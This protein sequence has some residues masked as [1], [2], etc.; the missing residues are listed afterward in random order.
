VARAAAESGLVAAVALLERHMAPAYTPVQRALAFGAV[1][2]ELGELREQALG[3]GRFSVAV[4]NLSGLLDLNQAGPEALVGLFSQFT[5]S[6]AARAIVDALQDWRDPDDL[7]RPQGAESAAYRRAGSPYIPPNT[8]LT[9]VEELRRIRGVS[10]T[11]ALAVA[12]YVTVNGDLLVDVNAAPEP[13]LAAIPGIGS[14]G[15]RMLVS[16]RSRG[17]SFA[18][19]AEVY[20][21]LGGEGGRSGAVSIAGLTVAPSRLLL[22]TRGWMPGHPL[23]HEIQAGYAMVGPSLVLQS[24]RERDL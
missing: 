14:T 4:T 8:P 18:S 19:L 17:G 16:R 20:S 7:V 11:L 24:W 5:S 10:D 15:A 2:S 13:V 6:T 12:P 9:R 3:N 23:T 1:Q 22:V 21:L